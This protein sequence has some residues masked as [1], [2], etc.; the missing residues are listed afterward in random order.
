MLH[1]TFRSIH[2]HLRSVFVVC[3]LTLLTKYLPLQLPSLGEAVLVLKE[4]TLAWMVCFW[5]MYASHCQE[6]IFL[7]FYLFCYDLFWDKTSPCSPSWPWP[8][9]RIASA[10][11]VLRPQACVSLLPGSPTFKGQISI[12]DTQSKEYKVKCEPQLASFDYMNFFPFPPNTDGFYR[13]VLAF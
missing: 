12:L 3:T 4:F 5:I 13:I 6:L 7:Y 2:S 11:W 8:Q 9:E 1:L 10:S